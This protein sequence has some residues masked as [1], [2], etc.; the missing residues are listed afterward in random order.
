M[1]T[2]WFSRTVIFLS[3]LL[4]FVSVQPVLAVD[5]TIASGTVTSDTGAALSGVQIACTA[6][7]IGGPATTNSS[8]QYTC[9]VD[10]SNLISGTTEIS[11]Q[12]GSLAGYR[13]PSSENYTW[14]GTAQTLNFE[15]SIASKTI[16]VVVQYEDGSPVTAVQVTAQPINVASDG[17]FNQVQEDFMNGTGDLTVGGGDWIVKADANLSSNNAADFPWVSITQPQTLTFAAD[18]SVESADIT[19]VV[20][21]SDQAVTV[22]LKDANGNTLNS[23]GV[24][25][26]QFSGFSGTYGAVTT[27][28][29]VNSSTGIATVYLLP[30]VWHILPTDSQ[31][32]DQSYN[33]DD[34]TFVLSSTAG[35]VDLG[36]ITALNNTGSVSGT[37]LI[38]GET[39][40]G[41]IDITATNI[42]TGE[43][44]P[45]GVGGGGEFS[46]NNLALGSYTITVSGQQYI[47]TKTASAT[48]TADVQ[49]VTDLSLEASAVDMTITGSVVDTNGT[50]LENV[51][52]TM[53][54]EGNGVVFSAPVGSDGSYSLDMYST[55]LTGETMELQFIPQPGAE[56]FAP[57]PVSVP[58]LANSTFEN[59]MTTS[60]DEATISG[61]ITNQ[62][63]TDL[64]LTDTGEH[65]QVL[66]LE[67]TTGAVETAPVA[68]DGSYTLEVGPGDW[69]IIPQ[70]S[71]VGLD[72]L[73]ATGS[74]IQ[75]SVE[76]GDTKT[77]DVPVMTLDGDVTI[78]IT[79]P[80]G[81]AVAEAPVL[82]TN[83]PALE[84]AADAA[85]TVVDQSEVVQIT[86]TT[87]GNGEVTKSLPA[88]DFTAFFGTNPDVDQYS[89]PAVKEFTVS[90]DDTTTVESHYEEAATTVS[91]DIGSNFESGSVTLY[92]PD[93]GTEVVAV[94]DDGSFSADVQTGD[95]K[96]V[97]TGEKNGEL[98][99]D[100]MDFTVGSGDKTIQPELAATG[101]DFPAATTITADAT[102]PIMLTNTAG[103]A[104]S[105][106]PYAAAFSGDVT[107]ALQP[108]ISFGNT[109]DVSQIGIAYDVTVVDEDGVA[110]KTLNNDATV[111]LPI[112]E[113]L[114]GNA[115]ASDMTG[116]Y[117]NPDL[118]SFLTDGISAATDG[119]AMVIHT[120]HLSRFAVTTNG[121]LTTIPNAVKFKKMSVNKMT[122]K[123]AILH[124]RE[125]V[126]GNVTK[127]KVQVRKQGVAQRTKW[128]RYNNVSALKK[129]LSALKSGTTYQFRVAACNAIGCTDFT[130]WK[131]FTTK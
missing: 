88:G 15:Y 35:D 77:K 65:A 83:L 56:V 46:V 115:A 109:G 117:Y 106:P 30:G 36:T 126:G 58:V 123:T 54:V 24:A 111:I 49:T 89:E 23:G 68:A 5:T 69:K 64:D 81:A 22:T 14:N 62:T 84:A 112:N 118:Q 12:P 74:S 80:D 45:G 6:N 97:L 120:K 26:V 57:E 55:G 128:D 16:N 82:L 18:T 39:P 94:G 86:A 102:E 9:M 116:T 41:L 93:G 131:A 70:L 7:G 78:T 71:D 1:Y 72:V 37:L 52:G 85:G 75:A 76:A 20:A 73:A 108:V 61:N 66:A 129:K 47:P 104:V 105:L 87:D 119:N 121:D 11:V 31:L 42:D 63:G 113:E 34:V 125:P 101:L 4:V 60:S 95:W 51:P 100:E 44:F 114:V 96:A 127:Y 40:S 27:T 53:I 25:D 8:G 50:A 38:D 21:Q 91:G 79:D 17:N 130:K 28:R 10:S 92:S 103:A 48:I 3:A 33:P 98:F 99:I 124:W 19:F 43:A 59:D 2:V 90:E 32:D 110:V 29:K 67:V 13:A 122:K 107:V